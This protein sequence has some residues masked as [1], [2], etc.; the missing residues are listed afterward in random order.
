MHVVVTRKL[1]AEPLMLREGIGPETEM[2]EAE[3]GGGTRVLPEGTGPDTGML[4][5]AEPGGTRVL[6][7]KYV[8]IVVPL[9][10]VT[11]GTLEELSRPTG[12]LEELDCSPDDGGMK[13]HVGTI[14]KL[15]E[16]ELL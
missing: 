8:V 13:L 7:E 1:E 14:E 12:L 3:I 15:A 9:T 5:M 6:D 4:E 2:L 16:L 11:S 10:M